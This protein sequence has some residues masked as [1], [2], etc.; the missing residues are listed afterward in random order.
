MTREHKNIRVHKRLNGQIVYGVEIHV[1]N[2]QFYTTLD[3]LDEAIEVR[4]KVKAYYTEH[5]HLP[6]RSLYAKSRCTSNTNE[7]YISYRKDLEAYMFSVKRGDKLFQYRSPTLE[8]AIEVRDKTLKFYEEHGRFPEVQDRLELGIKLKGCSAKTN[9]TKIT[10]MICHECGKQ[11]NAASYRRAERQAFVNRG[12]VCKTCILGSEFRPINIDFDSMHYISVDTNHRQGE[13][14]Y[15]LSICLRNESFVKSSMK[16]DEALDVRKRV[17]E[18]YNTNKRMPNADERSSL[19]GIKASSPRKTNN[20]KARS[21][22]GHR[23]ITKIESD[24][25]RIQITHDYSKFSLCF[26]TLEDA[27]LARDNI[28]KYIELNGHTPS[29]DIARRMNVKNYFE[30]LESVTA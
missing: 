7:Q 12:N 8:Y 2:S 27:V 14:L 23:H 1:K 10:E 3:S 26:N 4:D 18:F 9:Q 22:T 16:L 20:H 28:L 25:Y 21:G 11:L 13:K 19:F 15:R 30:N 5:G 24:S 6:D 29:K 17:I